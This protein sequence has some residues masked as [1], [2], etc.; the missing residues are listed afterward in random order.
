MNEFDIIIIGG[1]IA[2][3]SAAFHLAN[4]NNSKNKRKIIFVEFIE[5]VL[6]KN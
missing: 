5:F 1:G 4:K 3:S 2:G 6:F